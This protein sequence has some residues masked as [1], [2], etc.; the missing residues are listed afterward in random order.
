MLEPILLHPG[1]V[2]LGTPGA[3]GTLGC[4]AQPPKLS[5]ALKF[6]VHTQVRHCPQSLSMT[7]WARS[8]QLFF[9]QTIRPFNHALHGRCCKVCSVAELLGHGKQVTQ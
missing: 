4:P 2:Y 8:L 6:G 7:V 1:T 3:F 9:V 5:E